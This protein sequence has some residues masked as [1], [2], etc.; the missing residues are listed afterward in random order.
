MYILTVKTRT[1]QPFKYAPKIFRDIH[2][3]DCSI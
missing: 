3:D 1:D 2:F